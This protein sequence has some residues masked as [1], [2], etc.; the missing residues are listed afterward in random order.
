MGALSYLL[1]AYMRIEI[2]VSIYYMYGLTATRK[3][4]RNNSFSVSKIK[5]DKIGKPLLIEFLS[6]IASQ[7]FFG[8]D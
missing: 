6:N 5:K 2:R 4:T 3:N 1:F 7:T 8:K